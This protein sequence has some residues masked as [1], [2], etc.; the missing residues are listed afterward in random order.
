MIVYTYSEPPSK[1]II[2]HSIPDIRVFLSSVT[3]IT[4]QLFTYPVVLNLLI[5]IISLH[6]E[7]R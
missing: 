2:K 3:L 6:I 7:A 4:V 1:S 5:I